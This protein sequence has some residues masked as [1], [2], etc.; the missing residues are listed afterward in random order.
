MD[1][2]R[3]FERMQVSFPLKFLEA[4]ASEE[5][6]GE[7]FD[8]SANGIGLTSREKLAVNS[9]LELWLQIPEQAEPFYTRAEVVWAGRNNEN[10]MCNAGIRLEKAELMGLARALWNKGR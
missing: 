6:A 4:T 7:T 2:R 5:S 8:I 9:R 3:V 10:G 1:D